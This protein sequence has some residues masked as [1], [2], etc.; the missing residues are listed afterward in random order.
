ME[1][2]VNTYKLDIFKSKYR[3]NIKI[4]YIDQKLVKKYLIDGDI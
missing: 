2:V 3:F 4:Y 1:V